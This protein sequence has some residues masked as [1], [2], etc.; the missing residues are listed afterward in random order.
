MRARGRC[1]SGGCRGDYEDEAS[2]ITV[3][4]ARE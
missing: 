1:R 2:A 3:P 4:W